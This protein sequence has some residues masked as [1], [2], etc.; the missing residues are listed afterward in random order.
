M[1]ENKG[2][3]DLEKIKK[4]DQMAQ[5]EKEYEDCLLLIKQSERKIEE[6]E[7]D[8]YYP[9][10]DHYIQGIYYIEREGKYEYLKECEQERIEEYRKK[11]RELENKIKVERL[12]MALTVM[13]PEEIE[14]KYIELLEERYNNK[15]WEDYLKDSDEVFKLNQDKIELIEEYAQDSPKIQRLLQQ[16]K[17]KYLKKRTEDIETKIGE[18]DYEYSSSHNETEKKEL[19]IKILHLQVELGQLNDE[20]NK[21][22]EGQEFVDDAPEC[23]D[24]LSEEDAGFEINEHEEVNRPAK[25]LTAQE[26]KNMSE[27]ELQEVLEKNTR[28]IDNNNKALKKS[29]VERI[30]EQQKTIAEQ[31]KEI[32]ELTSQKKE[33]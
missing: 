27:E 1:R 31:Q 9:E 2:L 17:V 24:I 15:I 22:Q 4:F 28:M 30:L 26:L 8:D 3:N 7:K 6:Y 19:K 23:I 33:F 29:L 16:P 11:A 21:L 10:E 20:M 14:K 13:T 12:G 32:I 18:L 5:H 25:Q